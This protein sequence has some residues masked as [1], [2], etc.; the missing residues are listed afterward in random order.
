MDITAFIKDQIKLTNAI[1]C[2][3]EGIELS[4]EA[5]Q[6]LEVTPVEVKSEIE[7][8]M[9]ESEYLFDELLGGQNE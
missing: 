3:K 8:Q 2:K 7:I 5:E 4:E 9:I 6:I 1:Y